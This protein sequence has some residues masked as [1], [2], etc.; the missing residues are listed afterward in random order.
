MKLHSYQEQAIS[1]LHA[2]RRA[3]LFLDMGLGKTASVL[4]ALTSEHLPAL[5]VAPARVATETWPEEHL[6]WRPD[7]SLQVAHGSPRQRSDALDASTLPDVTV[8]SRNSLRDAVSRADRYRTLVIDE[9]SGFKDKMSQR[10]KAANKIGR[11]VEHVWELTGTPSPNGY[12]D[13]WAQI[14]LLDGG[15]RLGKT[16]GAYRERYFK[17]GFTLPN[18]VVTEWLLR[19]GAQA[20]I[21]E[22]IG[23][24]CMSMGTEGR[25]DLPPTTF[26]IVRTPLPAQARKVYKAMKDDF[27]VMKDLIGDV[28]TAA[29]AAVMTSKLSQI[30]AGFLYPDDDGNPRGPNDFNWIHDTKL[31]A[32]EEIIEGTGSPVLVFYNFQ[33]EL[34]KI[35]RRFKVRQV[36]EPGAVKDWNEGKIPVMVAHPAS[37]GH[38]LNLQRGGHTA[39]WTTPTWNLE[40]WEQANKRLSRQGQQ[41]PVMIHVLQAPHTVDEAIWARLADKK[42]IQQAL[43][44]YLDLGITEEAA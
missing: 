22:L 40:L 24:I 33:A 3:A 23:D 11:R 31:N 26:N 13:L 19:P 14:A 18:G 1:H 7:L 39:V 10:W 9:S 12:M 4:C 5:V 15:Q 27:I 34:A 6:I 38:G 41:H 42:S 36:N 43:T 32:L 30:T 20:R 2:H 37:A 29:N 16:L 21:N 44:E 17:P 35:Q 8:I 28:H 25:I